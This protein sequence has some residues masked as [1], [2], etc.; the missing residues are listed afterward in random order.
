VEWSVPHL[1]ISYRTTRA[2]FNHDSHTINHDRSH[3]P[4]VACR[5][6]ERLAGCLVGQLRTHCRIHRVHQESSDSDSSAGCVCS[7]EAIYF[8]VTLLTFSLTDPH[9][10][11]SRYNLGGTYTIRGIYFH[12]NGLVVAAGVIT[13][14]TALYL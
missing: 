13:F 2:L 14:L 5:S 10:P 6:L 7:F 8:D 11:G 12:A 3:C 9:K 1:K 4:Q